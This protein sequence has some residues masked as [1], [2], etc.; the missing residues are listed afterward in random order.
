MDDEGVFAVL[1]KQWKR[2]TV[3]RMGEVIAAMMPY[4][5]GEHYDRPCADDLRY[6][7]EDALISSTV[8]KELADKCMTCDF[9]LACREYG[10][11]HEDFGMWGATT[12]AERQAIRKA[13]GQAL[14]EPQGASFYGFIP[15]PFAFLWEVKRENQADGTQGS[16]EPAE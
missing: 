11:A 4:P 8:R 1:P 10:I 3:P 5:G 14:V 7:D 13:R 12:P 16:S 9:L 15:N 6:T 2:M